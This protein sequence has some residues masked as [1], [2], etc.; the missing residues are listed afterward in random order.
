MR[1]TADPASPA[2]RSIAQV[3]ERA[4]ITSSLVRRSASRI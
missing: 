3:C 4:V 2:V 1:E